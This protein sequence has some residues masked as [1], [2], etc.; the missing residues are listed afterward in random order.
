MNIK[1]LTVSEVTSYIKRVLDNDFILNNLS[2]KGEISNL[3]YH[4]S[5][6]IYFSIKDNS[7]KVNC[8][9]FKGNARFLDIKLE[10]G[11]EVIIC[12][13]ASIYPATGSFQIYC[14]EIKKE[15]QGELFI[16]FE[17]LKEK[18]SREGYFD[19]EHKMSIPEFPKRVGIVTSSTGAAIHDII[20]VSRRR[21]NSIDIVLY[22]AKVQG[23]D[24]YK[25]IIRGIEYF[26]MKN[27]VDVIIVGRGGYF[28]LQE[29]LQMRNRQQ[30]TSSR[31]WPTS[32]F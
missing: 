23:I 21:N 6:H 3:K 19:I 24:S 11:M 22:P 2:V 32:D 27:N 10:E 30:G 15:G 17:K 26:N 5:G 1:T 31:N 29:D 4:S 16:K 25:E 18:L 9:M 13:R 20:N 14:D 12:G 7:G 8:V 28:Y